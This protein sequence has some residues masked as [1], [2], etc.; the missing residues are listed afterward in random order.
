M[1]SLLRVQ[2]AGL[3][4]FT[5]FSTG[6]VIQSVSAAALGVLQSA[7]KPIP[8]TLS[9]CHDVG[10]KDM[11][12]PNLL[13]HDTMKEVQQQSGSWAPL[14]SKKCHPDTKKFLCSLFAP[15]CLPGLTEPVWPCRSLC[16]DVRNGCLPVMSAFGFP[17]PDM[18]HCNLFPNNTDLCI[19]AADSVHSKDNRRNHHPESKVVCDACNLAAEGEV[20]IKKNYCKSRFAVS[21]KVAESFTDG[22]DRK[23]VA[24][25]RSR[26]LLRNGVQIGAV[27][28]SQLWLL[29]GAN[30]SC[31]ELNSPLS[32]YLLGVGD[33]NGSRLV[34]TRLM[35]WPKAERELKKFMKS[36]QR[37]QCT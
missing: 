27:T 16:E 30:C 18:F 3:P 8:N 9:L 35:K 7:C 25:G 37:V 21:L 12:L 33:I 15:V 5:V 17:W 32:G 20:G 10:Y 6:I 11:R 26:L 29:Q 13:G 34:F 19:P 28:E 4:F 36:L 14:V 1:I 31:E 22:P 23:I 24:S 2:M